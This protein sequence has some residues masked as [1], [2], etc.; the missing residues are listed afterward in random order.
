MHGAAITH[1]Q[2]ILTWGVNDTVALGRDTTYHEI[3]KDGASEDD[4][5]EDEIDCGL[6]LKECTPTAIMTESLG[7]DAKAFVQVAASD[8]ATFALTDDGFVYGWGTFGVHG[9]DGTVGF[10][11]AGALE[12]VKKKNKEPMY[13]R[14]PV[15]IP[16]LREIKSVATGSNHVSALDHKGTV[17]AWGSGEQSQLCRRIVE[18]SRFQALIHVPL[19]YQK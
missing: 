18:R 15:L 1:N 10:S 7:N 19:V 16:Y 13:Q 14:Q 17:F 4:D 3:D 11:T 9:N 12:A 5:S 8:N 2:K 6:T